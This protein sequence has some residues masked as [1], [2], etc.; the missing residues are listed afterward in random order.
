MAGRTKTFDADLELKDAGLV[1]SSA[2]AQVDSAAQVVDL[3]AGLV[4]GDIVIDITACEVASGNE[5][6]NIGAQISSSSSFA[7]DIYEV[8]TLI[9]GDA[10]A[11]PGDVDMVE[12]RYFLGFKNMIADGTVKRYLRLYTTVAGTVATCINYTAYLAK[13]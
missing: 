3:G 8:A 9:V 5:V 2:A 4:E 7:S 11:I 1:A 12:G 6:Y 10:A 13:K